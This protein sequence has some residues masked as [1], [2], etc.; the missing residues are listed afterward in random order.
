MRTSSVV[1][2]PSVRPIAADVT[3][4]GRDHTRT[5][6]DEVSHPPE[7]SGDQDGV[8]CHSATRVPTH[9]LHSISSVRSNSQWDFSQPCSSPILLAAAT[10]FSTH[11]ILTSSMNSALPTR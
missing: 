1:A 5:F 9:H 11:L 6:A 4:L 2:V 8:S 3:H 7:A 10:A